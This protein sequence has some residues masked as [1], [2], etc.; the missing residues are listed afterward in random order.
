L[1]ED[2]IFSKIGLQIFNPK[3]VNKFFHG[4]SFFLL[5]FGA[6]K[7]AKRIQYILLPRVETRG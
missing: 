3:I 4:L 1:R 2:V 5:A 6:K 7:I